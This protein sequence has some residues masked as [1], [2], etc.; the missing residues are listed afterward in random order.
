MLTFQS[1]IP[2]EESEERSKAMMVLLYHHF[3]DGEPV[4]EWELN[5]EDFAAQMEYL[6]KEG[7]RT[8]SLEEFCAYHEKGEFPPKSVL[9]TFDDAYES[10]YTHAYPVLY[11]Y[12]LKSVVYP[13]L[14]YTPGLLRKTIYSPHLSF[15]QMRELQESNLVEFGSHT[16]GLH[17][18]R[19]DQT[20]YIEP[21]EG[22]SEEEY[23]ERIL[24]DLRVSR[25]LLYLQLDSEILSLAWPF[26]MST[27]LAQEIALEVGYEVLLCGQPGLV[28]S[29]T[30]LTCIP[31][32]SITSGSLQ[33]FIRLLRRL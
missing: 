7:Y 25:D 28:T 11:E 22:E 30:P 19:Q 4:S 32:Y 20:P 27:P 29:K 21:E 8:L 33:D 18:F 13:I 26:G 5:I 10:F 24:V 16:Y 14:E 1:S 3:V 15:S 12:G 6:K 9:L 31:R 2:G 23:R 17:H